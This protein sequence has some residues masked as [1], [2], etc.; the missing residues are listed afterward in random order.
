MR[1]LLTASAISAALLIGAAPAIADSYGERTPEE[2]VED[3]LDS[4]RGALQ[5]FMETLPRFE[6]P[7]ITDDGDIILRRQPPPEPRRVWPPEAP[8]DD[9][10]GIET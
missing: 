5:R 1:Q 7:I 4:L 10:G 6:A 8:A 9:F 2:L 3:G